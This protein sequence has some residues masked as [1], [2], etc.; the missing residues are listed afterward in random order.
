[1]ET[2]TGEQSTESPFPIEVKV[3]EDRK[4][5]RWFVALYGIDGAVLYRDII[6]LFFSIPNLYKQDIH[7]L[8]E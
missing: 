1:M 6:A 3:V 8:R 5:Q 2:E 4:Y 7:F